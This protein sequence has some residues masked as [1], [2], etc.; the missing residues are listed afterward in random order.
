M[1]GTA[2]VGEAPPTRQRKFLVRVTFYA[3]PRQGVYFV[4][5]IIRIAIANNSRPTAPRQ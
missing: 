1:S 4:S 2:A 3:V 5:S